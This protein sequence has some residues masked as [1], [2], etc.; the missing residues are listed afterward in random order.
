[1][2]VIATRDDG[3]VLVDL[4]D[5]YGGRVVDPELGVAFAPGP[6]RSI[7]ARGWW[8]EDGDGRDAGALVDGARR[9]LPPPAGYEE[10]RQRWLQRSA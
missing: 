3:A 8:T 1:M 4:E 6:L 2:K 7:L 9:V 10:A 5:G